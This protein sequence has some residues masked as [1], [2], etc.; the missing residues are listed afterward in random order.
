MNNFLHSTLQSFVGMAAGMSQKVHHLK[1]SGISVFVFHDVSNNI[2]PFAGRHALTVSPNIFQQQVTWITQNF[3]IIHPDALLGGNIEKGSALLTFDDGWEGTF[4]QAL[5][6]LEQ[7]N[8]PAVVFLNLQPIHNGS[9]LASAMADYLGN[10]EPS[11]IKFSNEV[12]MTAP[13][14]LSLTPEAYDAFVNK[15]GKSHEKKQ[16]TDQG[17]MAEISDLVHWDGHPLFRYANHLYNHWNVAALSDHELVKQYQKNDDLLKNYKS[18]IPF[19][20]YPNG[21]AGTCYSPE[22]SIKIYGLG[23]QRLFSANGYIN[24]SIEDAILS[25]IAL[26]AWHDRPLRFWYG[27]GRKELF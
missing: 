5:P 27:F 18:K 23:A 10:F 20:A 3:N 8:L 16:Q 4:Q 22:N 7:M 2:S 11:F 6:I 21:Q 15:N 17:K 26:T 13:Y 14:H 24:P 12:K 25:R 1:N 19:F 9:Y